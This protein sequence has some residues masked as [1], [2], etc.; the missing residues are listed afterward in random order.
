MIQPLSS[1]GSAICLFQ[2]IHER[3]YQ[4]QDRFKRHFIIINLKYM[5]QGLGFNAVQGKPA[6]APPEYWHGR[7]L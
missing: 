1:A 3:G 2:L 6:A 4:G 7:C 5:T